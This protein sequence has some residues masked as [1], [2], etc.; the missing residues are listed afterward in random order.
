VSDRE[1][2]STNSGRGVAGVLALATLTALWTLVHAI[3]IEPV[4]ELAAPRFATG[5]ALA[6]ASPAPAVDVAAAVETDPF[7]PDRSAPERRYRAP[8]EEGEDAAPREA[9]PEPVVLGTAVSDAAHSFATVQLADSR[10]VILR[11]GDKIGGYTVTSI[12]RRHV[13]FKTPSGKKL[14]ISELKP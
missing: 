2:A 3:R 11:V 6:V 8:G 1:W 5:G 9:Q 13:E 10:A 7:A 12:E 14:D 4:P